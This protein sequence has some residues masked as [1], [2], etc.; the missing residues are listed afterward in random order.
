MATYICPVCGYGM[1]DEPA[2]YNICPSCG[3]EFGLHDQ[4]ATIEELR[5][6]WIKTGL[7]WWS[8]TDS[9]PE[10]WD[11][12]I[13]LARPGASGV[14]QTSTTTTRVPISPGWLG[15]PEMAWDPSANKQ[16]SWGYK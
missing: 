9:Q 15:W 12:Y 5:A 14:I 3:T 2:N 11:P 16:F 6:T 4:N 10:G 7:K 1:E 8:K 13:Q